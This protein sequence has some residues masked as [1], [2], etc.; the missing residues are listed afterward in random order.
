MSF[1]LMLFFVVCLAHVS[2]S[3]SQ[4]NQKEIDLIKQNLQMLVGNYKPQDLKGNSD[5]V[6]RICFFNSGE[7]R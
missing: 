5:P 4:I 3:T 2:T 7:F 6:V 1:N